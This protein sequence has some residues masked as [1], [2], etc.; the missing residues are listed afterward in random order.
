ME[1]LEIER[2]HLNEFKAMFES[3]TANTTFNE[4]QTE[5]FI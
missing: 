2:T 3:S 1:K 5:F 4:D